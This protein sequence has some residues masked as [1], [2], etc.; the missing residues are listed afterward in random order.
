MLYKL[1]VFA[2]RLILG[3]TFI[4]AALFKIPYADEFA[5]EVANYRMPCPPLMINLTAVALPWIELLAGVLLIMSLWQYGGDSVIQRPRW[6]GKMS[7][8]AYQHFQRGALFI[9][10]GLLVFFS[11]L[12]AITIFRG[13]DIECGCFGPQSAQRVGVTKIIEN[14]A[15]F[16]PSIP[17]YF[18]LK[19]KRRNHPS[20][21]APVILSE[22]SK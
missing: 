7:W 2:C 20:G 18:S 17:L 3:G 13:I 9:L 4:A 21:K 11:I 15:F 8:F 16:L 5:R 1:F 22:S 14:L 19:N 12:L 10:S 6:L